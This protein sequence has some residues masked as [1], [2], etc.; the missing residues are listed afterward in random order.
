MKMW[1]V[2]SGGA[3]TLIVASILTFGVSTGIAS[4]S[5]PPKQECKG[6]HKNDPDCGVVEPGGVTYTAELLGVFVIPPRT[7][8][9]ESQDLVLRSRKEVTIERSDSVSSL[10]WDA[11]FD[12]CGLLNGTPTVA[13]FTATADKKGWTIGRPGGVQVKFRNIGTFSST[14]GDLD[15]TLSL[16]GDCEYSGGTAAC[17]PFPPAAGDTSE[18]PLTAYLVHGGGQPGINSVCHGERALLVPE[19]TLVITASCPDGLLP[20]CTS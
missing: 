6:H 1:N 7:V 9:L 18:I 4:A 11:V 2:V 16:I 17:D 14:L 12:F 13:N 19:S 15:L 3:S 10:T 8:V 20:P 5:E